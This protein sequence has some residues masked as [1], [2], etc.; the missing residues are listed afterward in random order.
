[1]IVNVRFILRQKIRILILHQV[2]LL[3]DDDD[4]RRVI[5]TVVN[6]HDKTDIF[7]VR[8]PSIPHQIPLFILFRALGVESDKEI[9][10]YILYELD[11]E[12]SKLFMDKLLP[13]IE[14]SWNVFTQADAINY[15]AQLTVGNT[16]SHLMSIIF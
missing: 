1:M 5:T 12:K 14:N 9:L 7:T 16:T 10:E 15:L 11:S 13:T 3:R 6:M 8:L 4:L 2:A